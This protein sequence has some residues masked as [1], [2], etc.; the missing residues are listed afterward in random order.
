MASTGGVPV[1]TQLTVG[2]R[3]TNMNLGSESRLNNLLGQALERAPSERRDFLAEACRD[4]SGL[5]DE[6][7]TLLERQEE[8][9]AGSGR[10]PEVPGTATTVFDKER[11]LP[12]PPV[13]RQDVGSAMPGSKKIGHYRLLGSLGKG[14]M[15]LVQ[16]AK[17]MKLGRT[18]ALKF[19]RHEL[20][21]RPE[22]KARFLREARA[23]SQLDHPNI[24][25]VHEIGETDDG[26]LYIVMA[27]Y[28][29]ETLK[30]RLDRGPLPI[31]DAVHIT[32]QVAAGLAK[33]HREGVVHRDIKP[34]NIFLTDDG[35]VKVLDFGV[36][37]VTGDSALTRTGL[38]IGTPFY[39]APEQ[40]IG[41]SDHRA[42]IWALGVILYEML[43]GAR[44]FSGTHQTAVI[45][46]VLNDPVPPVLIHRADVPPDLI[47]VVERA[48]A[49]EPDER[50][51]DAEEFAAALPS[52]SEPVQFGARPERVIAD[53]TDPTRIL[54]AEDVS[55]PRFAG[56]QKR[57]ESRARRSLLLPF[58]AG[59]L[60]TALVAA[61]WIYQVSHTPIEITPPPALEASMDTVT[62]AVLPFN[63]RGEGGYEY[64]REGMVDLLSTKLDGAGEI[65]TI[66]PNALL[67]RREVQ[68]VDVSDP[69]SSAVLGRY[70]D[71]DLLILGNVFE[72]AHQLRFDAAVYRITAGDVA[73][74][75]DAS[76]EG[77]AAEMFSLVDDLAI[78]LLVGLDSTAPAR[79]R[80]L[81]ALTSESFPALKSYLE[82]ENAWRA[83][84]FGEAAGAFEIAVAQDPDFALAWYRLSQAQNWLMDL[85]GY[86]ASLRK[87]LELSDRLPPD[88][89]RLLAVAAALHRGD[90]EATERLAQEALSFRP[91]DLEAW[92]SLGEMEFHLGPVLG[93]SLAQSRRSW[94]RVL[95][96]EPDDRQAHLHMARIESY[97][98]DFDA[99]AERN[100]RLEILLEG[101]ER[102]SESRFIRSMLPW[103]SEERD[104][105]RRS[106]LSSELGMPWLIA[107]YSLNNNLELMDFWASLHQGLLDADRP[108]RDRSFAHRHLGLFALSSG[109]LAEADQHL[110]QANHP[111]ERPQEQRAL[112]ATLPFLPIS[113]ES[114]SALI[115]TVE[116]W[117][118][119]STPDFSI[120]APNARFP[121]H[122]RLYILA[123][124]Q[125]RAGNAGLARQL[126]DE[127][128]ALGEIESAPGLVQDLHNGI[129]ADLAR[130]EGQDDRVLEWTASR[131]SRYSF[132]MPMLS[133]LFSQSRERY[134]RAESLR[135][136]GRDQEAL[137][138]YESL[139]ELAIFDLVYVGISHLR[140]AEIHQRLGQPQRAFAQY[141]R[142]IKRWQDCDPELQPLVEGAREQLASLKP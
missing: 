132:E 72:A 129:H 91:D 50:Y 10:T 84:R 122:H 115:A 137:G 17:D 87:A 138:W 9:S 75:A 101:S 37:K 63:V 56:L 74:I 103:A 3:M 106:L 16:R 93:R 20:Y 7:L 23:A 88:E 128:K 13:A 111:P 90:A 123:L 27:C 133:P 126:A 21:E 12:P 117:P 34:A 131:H 59:V 121:A 113:D 105:L 76:A 38:S 52:L 82:G 136:L 95:E 107:G 135:R 118:T 114:L 99:L 26:R 25:T 60:I 108:A 109:R 98:L 79:T 22:A 53:E 96:L 35:Q 73:K 36:A 69:Q 89:R 120:F 92:T 2:A 30:E 14:G 39:M 43:I 86:D 45:Q 33:A 81:A 46:S 62:V 8:L 51:Q 140:R 15:G 116:K 48:L 127:L 124:L 83:G 18:V 94:E 100:E 54:S 11:W 142:F 97:E 49:K 65:R 77:D 102:A 119:E 5:L 80:R 66:D 42:D 139:S 4:D 78:Q 31:T 40:A 68:P 57:K 41:D 1:G 24:C 70:F 67:R 6:A 134:L 19:L 110:K 55:K 61:G 28:D 29:G 112:A 32:R 44:P 64:L 85:E 104:A 58:L 47:H 130:L 71:S 141:R 125:A